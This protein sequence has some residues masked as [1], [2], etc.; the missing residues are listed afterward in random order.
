MEDVKSESG[1]KKTSQK[2]RNPK[3]TPKSSACLRWIEFLDCQW[4]KS[5]KVW[6]AVS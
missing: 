3:A 5:L 4:L 1:E 2:L 6:P